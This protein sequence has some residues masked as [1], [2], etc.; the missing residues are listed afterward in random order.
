MSKPGTEKT[1]TPA[2]D[3]TH[4]PDATS[5]DTV[6]VGNDTN[7]GGDSGLAPEYIV[8]IILGSCAVPTACILLIVFVCKKYR[9]DKPARTVDPP[10]E[11]QRSRNSPSI[12]PYPASPYS[13]PPAI[14][15]HPQAVTLTTGPRSSARYETQRPAG[16][17]VQAAQAKLS[18]Q[19]PPI[20]RHELSTYEP[21]RGR[22]GRPRSARLQK[23]SSSTSDPPSQPS[24]NST[25]TSHPS[26]SSYPSFHSYPS[27]RSYPSSFSYPHS[28]FSMSTLPSMGYNSNPHVSLYSS[29]VA[30]HSA[31]PAMFLAR[32]ENKNAQFGL[33]F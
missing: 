1:T 32:A 27:N 14:Y 20:R 33:K 28:Q 23:Q 18:E 25:P 16:Q 4:A 2:P 10:V 30:Y 11:T 7:S 22:G 5:S 13:R 3:V 17:Q 31:K 6:T 26:L 21:T 8:L 19:T 24:Q 29:R 12:P 15:R 9:A